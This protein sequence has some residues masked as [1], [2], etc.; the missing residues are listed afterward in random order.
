VI[1]PQPRSARSSVGSA[2]PAF[3]KAMIVLS[4]RSGGGSA[5]GMASAGS[6]AGHSDRS[7]TGDGGRTSAT[8]TGESLPPIGGMGARSAAPGVTVGK[9]GTAAVGGMGARAQAAHSSRT[10]RAKMSRVVMIVIIPRTRAL[11]PDAQT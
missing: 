8:A 9:T 11:T 4:S 6:G 1:T 5:S 10:G 7:G 3:R 2:P